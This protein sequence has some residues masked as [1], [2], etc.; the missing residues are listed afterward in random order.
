MV[1]N[2]TANIFQANIMYMRC[3]VFTA[4]WS[5]A[6]SHRIVWKV[7]INFLEEPS[8]SILRL[9]Q[10]ATSSHVSVTAYTVS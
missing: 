2:S 8:V 6:L 9:M 3:D 5:S 10:A 4:V 7:I 1:T